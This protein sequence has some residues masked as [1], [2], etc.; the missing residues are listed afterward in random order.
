M[1]IELTAI[2]GSIGIIL[3]RERL[4]KLR[5]GEG[6]TLHA[7]ELSDGIKLTAYDPKQREV[8][9]RIMEKNR[10]LLKKLADS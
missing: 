1:K 5:V 4:A 7:T 2:G 6:D 3:P 9:E 8:A 10:D